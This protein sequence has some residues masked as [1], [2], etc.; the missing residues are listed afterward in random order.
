MKKG[1]GSEPRSENTRENDGREVPVPLFQQAARAAEVDRANAE[2]TPPMEVSI[3]RAKSSCDLFCCCIMPG[4]PPPPDG[5][6]RQRFCIEMLPEFLQIASLH[7]LAGT[8][9]ARN[10]VTEESETRN[11]EVVVA[12]ASPVNRHRTVSPVQQS[13]NNGGNEDLR[14]GRGAGLPDEAGPGARTAQGPAVRRSALGLRKRSA[15]ER[16]V[17]LLPAEPVG[18]TNPERRAGLL[19]GGND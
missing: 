14:S 16:L 18:P 13:G 4:S 19:S 3:S 9:E 6:L 8:L 5:I 12:S 1:T 7:C 17:R 11:T 2:I 10:G 15:R